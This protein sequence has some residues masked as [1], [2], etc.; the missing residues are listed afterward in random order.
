GEVRQVRKEAVRLLPP[1]PAYNVMPLKDEVIG[2]RYKLPKGTM[3]NVLLPAL[4][5]DPRVWGPNPDV[6]NPGNFSRE[7]QA[8]RPVNTWKPFGN[9]RR[10][11]IGRAVAVHTATPARCRS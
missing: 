5:R 8:A 10:A 1:G 11:C 3:V 7:A 9:G 4:H 6:F 2:G